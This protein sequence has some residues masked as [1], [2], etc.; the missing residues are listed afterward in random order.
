MS[1]AWQALILAGGRS[2]RMGADKATL[3]WR[4]R[5]LLDHLVG[6]LTRAGAG[7][8]HIAGRQPDGRG[9][10]DRWPDLGPLGGLASALPAITDGMLLVLPVD[11]PLLDARAL[12]PL[13]ANPDAEALRYA[14]EALPLRLRVDAATRVTVE[15]LVESPAAQRSLD[16]LFAQLQ[17]IEITLPDTLRHA[18]LNCN[19]PED[20]QL[21]LASREQC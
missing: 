19:T 11:L 15:R 21:A 18:L 1:A 20:W 2:T 6:V 17:G 12:G 3:A 5:P 13:L 8:V 14:G 4:G 9:I 10:A 16:R 7:A